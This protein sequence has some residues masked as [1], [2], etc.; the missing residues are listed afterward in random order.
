M[1]VL[2]GNGAIARGLIEAGCDIITGYPGTPSSEIIPFAVRFTKEEG[3]DTYIEWSAN[4][5]VAF[6][7]AYAAS[8]AG[9][10]AAV[11]MKQV[12]LNVASDSLMSAAYLGVVGGMVIISC[13]DPGPHSSQ[14]EQ[15]TRLFAHFA[16]VPVFDP[17]SPREAV[18]M[19]REAFAVSERHRIPVLFRAAIRVCHAKQNVEFGP[20][21]RTERKAAFEKNPDRWAATPKYRFLLH[22]ELNVKLE[23]LGAEFS[24]LNTFNHENLDACRPPEG[25]TAFPLGIVAGGVP[26]AAMADVLEGEGLKDRVPVLK[27]GAPH[28]FPVSLVDGFLGRC[29]K[30]LVLEETDPVIELLTRE[31]EKILGRY[32]GHVPSAGEL[33]PEK[34]RAVVRG[35]VGE[36]GLA[37]IPKG[38]TDPKL[39]GL[40]A[41]L[42]LP[43]IRP[44]LCPGCGH[45]AAFFAIRRAFPKAIF[46]SDIGCY[47]LGLNL[48]AVDTVLDMGAAITMASGFH[49]AYHQDGVQKPVV[50]TI[51]D[52][53]FYHAGTAG[54]LSAVYNKARFILVIL[55]NETTAM[56]GMQP[57]PGIGARA[58]GSEGVKIPLE[59]AV[60]GCGVDW[61]RVADPFHYEEFRGLLREAGKYVKSDDGGIAV[62]ISRRP[63]H[64]NQK[65]MRKTFTTRVEI[66]TECNG[67]KICLEKFECPGIGFDE[68]AERAFIDRLWCI[69]C[70]FCLNVCPTGAI[71]EKG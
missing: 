65:A 22:E 8:I 28:P 61:I 59:R 5:K 6:D 11:V 25:A 42:G 37:E 29:E 50:A 39:S 10:R 43:V 2:I 32:S 12:G 31:R 47:T 34:I 64:V 19:L 49:Q 20:I 1:E 62:I 54:L 13:D 26:W 38:G 15:D 36:A 55:D 71:V 45:R 56:T 58:D 27:L 40:L 69:D 30:V 4:E 3:L 70:G 44:S 35:A 57:T 23:K 60:K 7:N 9:K 63:C 41:E 67:C 68:K 14:T 21:D 18:A 51:G 53:T 48:G 66:L 17:S 52:S 33:T 24:S 16:K 46:T